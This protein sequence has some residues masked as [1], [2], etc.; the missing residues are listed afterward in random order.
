ME[1]KN[2]GGLC[3]D[4]IDNKFNVVN[5]PKPCFAP[6]QFSPTLA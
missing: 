1:P 4:N 3:L 2:S 5:E 6:I